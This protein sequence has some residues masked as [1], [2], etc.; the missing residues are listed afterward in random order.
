MPSF[1]NKLVAVINKNIENGKALNA[2]AHLC[3][4]L[5]P[6]LD[7]NQLLFQE[8]RDADGGSHANISALPFLLL[9]GNTAKI[10]DLR[11][12][13]IRKGIQFLDFTDTMTGGEVLQQL[14]RTGAT[15]EQDLTYYGL[16]LFGEWNLV[17]GLTRRFSL[18]R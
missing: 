9:S 3:L 11:T 1:E 5:G 10:R 14:E 12:E 7:R 2:L 15:K 13:V 18:W 16:V 4:G 6:T 8:F 17:S